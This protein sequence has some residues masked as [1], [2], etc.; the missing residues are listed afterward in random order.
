ML[1]DGHL[2]KRIVPVCTSALVAFTALSAD[3]QTAPPL[4]GYHLGD[5]WSRIGRAMPCQPDSLPPDWNVKVKHCWPGTLALWF[6]RDTLYQ[7]NYTLPDSALS[8]DASLPAD[9]LWDRR[10]KQWSIRRFGEPDSVK[11]ERTDP[12]DPRRLMQVIVRWR[13][14]SVSV[15]LTIMTVTGSREAPWVHISVCGERWVKCESSWIGLNGVAK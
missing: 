8:P 7:I 10:W 11:V 2:A 12:N 14:P 9:A 4:A 3:G 1:V 15:Q 6:L 13:K 5:T